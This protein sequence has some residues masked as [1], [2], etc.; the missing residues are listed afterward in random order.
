MKRFTHTAMLH[1]HSSLCPCSLPGSKYPIFQD[2]GSKNHILNVFFGRASSKVGYL[3]PLGYLVRRG[4][5]GE[6]SFQI[7]RPPGPTLGPRNLMSQGLGEGLVSV[8]MA[9][10]ENEM[11]QLKLVSATRKRAMAQM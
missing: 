2:S 10:W 1:A 9:S 5:V 3:D 11:I 7:K 6:K 4:A 8:M